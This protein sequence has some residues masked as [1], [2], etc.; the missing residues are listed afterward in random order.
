MKKM[1][2]WLSIG[3]LICTLVV[4]HSCGG[5]V[6]PEP[7]AG[8]IILII[9]SGSL[10]AKTVV[11]D[12][13]MDVGYYVV[14]GEGPGGSS[15]LDQTN[16]STLVKTGLAIGMWSVN[17]EAWNDEDPAVCI[18]E[19]EDQS[20]TVE[21]GK[22]T[23]VIVNVLPLV[24]DG[25]L[26]IYITW[27]AGAI[28][29]PV[30][31]Y[32]LVDSYGIPAT[33]SNYAPVSL[34]FTVNAAAGTAES[35]NNTVKAGYYLL[36]LFL[37]SGDAALWM[38]P[39]AV[40]II[41]VDQPATEVR[42]NLKSDDIAGAIDLSVIV[43]LQDPIDIT[44]H[45]QQ[46]LLFPDQELTVTAD[47]TVKGTPVSVNSYRWYVGGTVFS[48]S[49]S[50]ILKGSELPGGLTEGKYRVDLVVWKYP[51]IASEYFFFEVVPYELSVT[52]YDSIDTKNPVQDVLVF[53]S[54]PDTG[55][56]LYS[57]TTD[58]DG[59]AELETTGRS[60]INLG[61]AY[62]IQDEADHFRIIQ[63]MYGVP[64]GGDWDVY[65]DY[66]RDGDDWGVRVGTI[67]VELQDDLPLGYDNTFLVPMGDYIT[68]G[69]HDDVAVYS[70]QIQNDGKISIIGI[71][72]SQNTP[73]KYGWLLDQTF[74]DGDT[75]FIPLLYDD[76][77]PATYTTNRYV[78]ELSVLTRR[79]GVRMEL[80]SVRENIPFINASFHLLNRFPTEPA[81]YYEL[82]VERSEYVGDDVR[83]FNYGEYL[84]SLP[85]QYTINIP[86]YSVMSVNFDPGAKSVSWTNSG[87]NSLV[88]ITLADLSCSYSIDSANY[89]VMWIFVTDSEN[90]SVTAPEL[91]A[92]IADWFDFQN[93]TE[94]GSDGHYYYPNGGEVYIEVESDDFADVE[95]FKELVEYIKDNEIDSSFGPDFGAYYMKPAPGYE[96]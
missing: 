66:G 43:D 80:G 92:E 94:P 9:D 30:I 91:P 63:T 54:D 96:D 68:S 42:V 25:K 6:G 55:S 77:T 12:V 19:S 64:G 50:L 89:Q 93:V 49:S 73:L 71:A 20:I 24:G 69:V 72:A 78:N 41:A 11:P 27:P 28:S 65:L 33:T 52:I 59:F 32:E 38:Q 67:D 34:S 31:A 40:R 18:G 8:S 87:Q 10:K 1:T 23:P 29:N 16:L 76:P 56:L 79:R 39:I 13:S 15:F 61:L 48:T 22:T 36:T 51:I 47:T 44:F 4:L 26:S 46:E 17:V 21:A 37:K 86:E 57:S 83:G 14:K 82:G 53:T 35:A 75:Y 90:T 45:G 85:S 62:E 84:T 2:I 3:L 74:T 58:T 70:H 81:N 5:K 95:G 88:D 7:D 60:Q